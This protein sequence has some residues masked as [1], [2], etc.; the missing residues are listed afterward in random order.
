MAGKCE[1][2]TVRRAICALPDERRLRWCGGCAAAH[3]GATDITRK[4]DSDSCAYI[5]Y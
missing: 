1:D 5:Y 4:Y 2:C 3:P